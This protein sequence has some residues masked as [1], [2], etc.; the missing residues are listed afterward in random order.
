V[1][2][3]DNLRAHAEREVQRYVNYMRQHGFYAEGTT[4]LGHDLVDEL[5]EQAPKLFERFPNAVFFGGQLVFPHDTFL[6]RWL[7]N[8]V[9]F[10][11]QR[12]FYQLGIPFLILPIRV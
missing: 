1:A 6:T 2:E 8:Y 9:V 11:L 12:R 4:A 5:A 3:L 10:A 7:H